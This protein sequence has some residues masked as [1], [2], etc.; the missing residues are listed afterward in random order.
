MGEPQE[1]P[2]HRLAPPGFLPLGP[3][4]ATPQGPV[5]AWVCLERRPRPPLESGRGLGGLGGSGP[6]SG[7]TGHGRGVGGCSQHDS[8][9]GL[10]GSLVRLVT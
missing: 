4:L 3:R 7:A 10:L 1:T 2:P 8:L 6:V 9:S 5:S